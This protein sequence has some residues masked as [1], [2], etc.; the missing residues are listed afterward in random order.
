[1][2]CQGFPG[3]SDGKA[4]SCNAG[5]L[6]FISG[7]STSGRG[8]G[9]PLQYSCLENSMDRGAWWATVRGVTDATERLKHKLWPSIPK[10]STG[11]HSFVETESR[12]ILFTL[13]AGGSPLEISQEQEVTKTQFIMLSVKHRCVFRSRGSCSL[14][15]SLWNIY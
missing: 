13:Q 2:L 5:N 9:N 14:S 8:H 11:M 7:F 6:A 12:K 3:G 15:D 1:M 4:S 10:Q